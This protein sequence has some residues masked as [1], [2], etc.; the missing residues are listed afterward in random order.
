[1][2]YVDTKKKL[3][4]YTAKKKGDGQLERDTTL[5]CGRILRLDY[6]DSDPVKVFAR[7]FCQKIVL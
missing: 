2:Q 3:V 5:M 1:M 7:Y 6:E 4:L